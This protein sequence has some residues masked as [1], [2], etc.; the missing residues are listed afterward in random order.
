MSALPAIAQAIACAAQAPVAQW[1]ERR[2]PKA[3]VVGS[4]PT[5]GTI[6]FNPCFNIYDLMKHPNISKEKLQKTKAVAVGLTVTL[7]SVVFGILISL[8][9]KSLPERV[10]NPIAP[11]ASLK[12]TK[13][14]LYEEQDELKNEIKDLQNNIEKAQTESENTTLSKQEISSLDI[15]KAQAGLTKL[16]GRGVI[17]TLNDGG[18]LTTEDSIVH[19]ADL[20]DVI[21]LL[22]GSGAEGISINGQRVVINTAIDC[23]VNTIL[24]NDIRLS[25]PFRIEAVGNQ[26]LMYSRLSNRYELSGLHHRAASGLVFKV[27][28]NND[29][30]LPVFDGSFEVK[31]EAVN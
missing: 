30:T 12:E 27:E 15:K 8:Q 4:I 2:R 5:R 1:I 31:T 23:I 10:T 14:S 13:E 18:G 21:N 19:A 22:W 7:F 11:Y 3:G 6:Q 9:W 17:I 16:N 25:A 29:I 20:R 24:V 26:D 28:K